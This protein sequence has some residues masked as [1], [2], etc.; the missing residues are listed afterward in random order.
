MVPGPGAHLDPR[1]V[2][3]KHRHQPVHRGGSADRLQ[4]Y[5][6]VDKR[7]RSAYRGDSQG[8][9]SEHQSEHQPGEAQSALAAS[10]A[11]PESGQHRRKTDQRRALSTVRPRLDPAPTKG[12][13]MT[14]SIRMFTVADNAYS[15]GTGLSARVAIFPSPPPQEH[16]T[17]QY[18]LLGPFIEP[19]TDQTL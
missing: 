15:G 11:T 18:T 2:A 10:I 6:L 16:Y 19:I 14:S 3:E 5:A 17:L 8:V 13:P 1:P 12:S 7:S 9:G 4:R